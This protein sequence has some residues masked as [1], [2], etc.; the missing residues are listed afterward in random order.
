M[1]PR[2][3]DN[4]RRTTLADVANA[5][6]VSVATASYVLTNRSGVTISAPTRERVAKYAEELGYRRNALAAA[7]R[8]GRTREVA[9]FVPR[10]PDGARGAIAFAIAEA[11]AARGLSLVLH[12][13][14]NSAFDPAR[15]DGVIVLG[16]GTPERLR[17][18]LAKTSVVEIG[19]HDSPCQI[20][21]DYFG[22]ARLGIEHL[23]SLG[24]RR[25]AHF[26]GTQSEQ[27]AQELLRGFLDAVHEAGLRMEASPVFH[28][29][30]EL[31][32]QLPNRL[33][34]T[35]I[36]AYSDAGALAVL[37][38]V[39]ALG[40]RVPEDISIVGF[41]DE[42]FSALLR[43]SLTT[44]RLAPELVALNA[45]TLLESQLEGDEVPTRTL[46][47]AKLVVRGS[48]SAPHS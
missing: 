30:T 19:A 39:T 5:A 28:S 4:K 6:G 14:E 40:L 18:D 38:R 2:R 10:T 31:S 7:L 20:H 3:A 33:R 34:P 35:A 12:V 32:N 24:H 25:I 17:A 43:P 44:L 29:L 27:A 46:I 45:L 16:S 36:L 37:D 26:A 23:F 11:A 15:S 13:G 9:L 47:P 1:P 42:P 41:G 8:S 48:T 21:G 22:G